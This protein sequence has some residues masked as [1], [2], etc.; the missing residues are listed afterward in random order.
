[1]ISILLLISFPSVLF[2]KL[3]QK[4]FQTRT[5]YIWYHRHL[6]VS[7]PFYIPAKFKYLLIFSLSFIFT[8]WPAEMAKSTKQQFLFFLFFSFFF[9][10]LL[11]FGLVFWPELSD[12]FVSQNRKECCASHSP[13][14][15]LVCAFTIFSMVKSYSQFIIFLSRAKSFTP[16]ALV[17][18]IRL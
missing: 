17:C 14:W 9:F 15:N 6:H 4:Q 16:F 12:L 10:C 13:G 5:Y 8:L 7:Q 18:W 2:F 3:C 1:M 11:L